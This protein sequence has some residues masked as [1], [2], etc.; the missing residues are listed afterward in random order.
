MGT[1]SFMNGVSVQ[2]ASDD[3][4]EKTEEG[5]AVRKI[6]VAEYGRIAEK[7]HRAFAEKVGA[8]SRW[9][10]AMAPAKMLNDVVDSLVEA[11]P[12]T[13]RGALKQIETGTKSGMK[14]WVPTEEPAYKL[15]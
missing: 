4:V 13:F 6:Y 1:S 7:R 3:T 14:S 15:W 9:H 2:G 11:A 10:H 5:A 12:G 8:F